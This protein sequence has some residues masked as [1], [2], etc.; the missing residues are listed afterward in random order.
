MGRIVGKKSGGRTYYYLT[1]SARVGGQPR[2]TAQRYLG[3][4][5]DI[6]AALDGAHALPERSEH[7]TFGDAAAAL[8]TMDRIG[9]AGTADEIAGDRGTVSAGTALT[10]AVLHRICAPNINL[11]RWWPT[12]AASRLLPVPRPGEL[13]RSLDRVTVG[14]A[15]A[16]E[17]AVAAAALARRGGE[18][19]PL[20][21]DV[22]DFATFVDGDSEAPAGLGLLV[23]RDGALPLE[24]RLYRREAGA[25]MPVAELTA[26]AAPAPTLVFEAGGSAQVDL[27]AVPH[28][29]G[30]LP[31]RDCPELRGAPPE[32]RVPVDPERLPGVTALEGHRTVLGARRRVVLTHS[33]TLHTAQSRRFAQAPP[34]ARGQRDGTARA[35]L[36][37]E[38]FGKLLLV[39]DHEGWPVGDV[40]TAYRARYYVNSTLRGLGDTVVTAPTRGWHWTERRRRVHKLVRVLAMLATHLMRR[41]A[42]LAGIDLSV[43]ELLAELSGI[44]ETVLRYPSTGGRPRTRRLLTDRSPRQQRLFEIFGVGDYHPGMTRES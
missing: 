42:H 40:I 15:D 34:S 31:L 36:D 44:G 4:A 8:A 38:Y 32:A 14:Q 2:V 21:L 12:S 7:L 18:A 9:L 17:R 13:G 25:V 3:S 16:I 11:A 20:V 28:F 43:R 6:A 5:E 39:T 35:R 26:G 1:E 29:V 27:D 37:R 30:A 19:V 33:E 24:S 22:P 23:A 10:A 41:Q